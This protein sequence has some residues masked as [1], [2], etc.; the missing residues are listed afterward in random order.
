MKNKQPIIYSLLIISGI[1]IGTKLVNNPAQKSVNT[2]LNGILQLIDSHYVDTLNTDFD[3]KIIISILKELDPHSTYIPKKDVKEVSENMAGSFSGIGVEFNIIED[4]IVVISAISG[5]PSEKLGIQSGDRIVVVEG[6]DVA[7]IGIENKGVIDRLRGE[8]GSIVAIK[9][10]RKGTNKLIDFNI[11]RDDIPLYSMDVGIMLTDDIGYIKLNRFAATT[12]QEFT[13]ASY[14][15]LSKGMLKL[16]LDLRGNPGGYLGAA[17]SICDAFLEENKLMVYT[18]GR[19]RSK[20]E[21]LATNS[22]NLQQTEV[23]VL[24]NEGSA[25]AAEIVAG[26]IQDNDRGTIVG[27]RSFGKGLVQEEIHLNDGSAVRITT[28]RYYTP[29]GRCI[30]K[31]YGKNNKEYY[32]EQYTRD[33]KED[34]ADS[35]QYTTAKGRTVYGG[36]GISPDIVIARDST[37]N[38]S[39]INFIISKGWVNTFSINFAEKN[40]KRWNNNATAYI[41]NTVVQEEIYTAFKK[42]AQEKDT[43]INFAM[44]AIEQAYFKNLLKANIARNIW[45]NDAYYT[46]LVQKDEFVAEAIIS[47]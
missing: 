43:S 8:K 22:G 37:L 9:I 46:I 44:G 25:S 5:G 6:E 11:K 38:Y 29:S 4:T 35:L 32:M 36:G 39:K 12:A 14:K 17:A 21:I 28:Q 18:E 26:A 23:I 24:I 3:D 16:I 33:G 19:N 2:K 40:R 30:Q 27:R 34:F 47:F 10:K 20:Q 15:L 7:S 31:P 45:D 41:N 42:Y 1:L 13:Q